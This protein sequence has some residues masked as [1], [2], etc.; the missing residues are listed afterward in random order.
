MW[1]FHFHKSITCF[2]LDC[3]EVLA[4][5]ATLRLLPIFI[6]ALNFWPR[7]PNCRGD[8]IG[9]PFSKDMCILKS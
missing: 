3:I 2:Q 5:E 7:F 6:S 8:G 4:R 9:M 1:K